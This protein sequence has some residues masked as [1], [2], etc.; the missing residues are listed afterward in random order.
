MHR[1]KGTLKDE[2]NKLSTDSSVNTKEA[3]PMLE[4]SCNK[5]F[6]AISPNL[7]DTPY[8]SHAIT[9]FVT[10]IGIPVLARLRR[11]GVT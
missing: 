11:H 4:S 10:M 8:P 2:R 5:D 9:T 7:P 1:C 3:C 6:H